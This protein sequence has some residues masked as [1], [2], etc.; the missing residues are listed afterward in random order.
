[1]KITPKTAYSIR[2]SIARKFALSIGVMSL[3][4]GIVIAALLVSLTI[5]HEHDHL[6]QILDHLHISV[7]EILVEALWLTNDDLLQTVLDGY[8]KLPGI[9]K[10]V[11]GKNDGVVFQEGEAVSKDFF[12]HSHDL[13]YR[14]Q[15][16]D[17]KLGH[18]AVTVGMD[19][20][21]KKIFYETL[22]LL[23][24]IGL[25]AVLGG[26]GTI[27]LFY[28]LVGR[29]LQ[30]IADHCGAL[31]WSNL[32]TP[33]ILQRKPPK[34]SSDELDLITISLNETCVS[35]DSSMSEVQ[36]KESLYKTIVTNSSDTILRMDRQGRIIYANPAAEEQNGNRWQ[37][38]LDRELSRETFHR[39]YQSKQ[40]SEIKL[41]FSD[42]TT[43]KGDTSFMLKLVP[44]ISRDGSVV[45]IVGIARNI[46]ME[47]QKED[48][49]RAVFK[50][51]PMP[52]AIAEI[53]SG[54]CYDVNDS[55]VKATGYQR[56]NIVDKSSIAVGFNSSENRDLVKK[57]LEMYG[58]F[59]DLELDFTHY[60]GSTMTCR[61]S[62]QIINV[63]GS[64]KMLSLF[65]DVTMEN[66]MR[67]E[68]QVLELQLLQ[69][70]KIEAI[71]TLAGGI[72]HDFN[73]ILMA[74]LGYGQMALEGTPQE[75]PVHRD[76]KQILLAA[77][78]ATQLTK[79]ILLFS[80]QGKNE[81]SP[82]R[83]QEIIKEVVKLLRS[84]IPATI[85]I[86]TDIDMNCRPA[87][88]DPTQIHQ[89][90]MNILTNARQ[91]VGGRYGK[92]VLTLREVDWSPTLVSVDG[93]PLKQCTYLQ[94]IIEDSGEGMAP[95]VLSR[96][97]EP[98]FTTKVKGE[99][100]GM[101][102]AVCHGIIS[103]HKGTIKV[104]SSPG[105]GA[106]FI[107]NLPV[108][109]DSEIGLR[110]MMKDVSALQGCERLLLVDDEKELLS[111]L[112]RSLAILGYQTVSFSDSIEGLKYF[113]GH[114]D[115]LD[116]VITDMTM[117]HLNGAEMSKK[118]LELRPDLP[119]I[120]CT[121]YSDV[122]D[123]EAAHEMGIRSYILKPVIISELATRM[124]KIFDGQNTEN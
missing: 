42:E 71:G 117:P 24:V 93:Q 52:M 18:I 41:H 85:E 6:K 25:L 98:F 16:Q 21:N 57:Q 97:F 34:K 53:D 68:Q 29:H 89:V 28:R 55:F 39:I 101:G 113:R 33:L 4:S 111:M 11:L 13:I 7:E 59:D 78:R 70:S 45:G 62:G 10:V 115:E 20:V 31:N 63:L 5:R 102:M 61:W 106:K 49:L 94:L 81:L 54:K 79:Q 69:A 110:P 116:M 14:Y 124:R 32:K 74:I 87:L 43:G 118:M 107:I 56:D 77:Q 3:L 103:R 60:N 95:E 12:M 112:E 80:R 86:A 122:L 15:G 66:K 83:L 96:I 46:T 58:F 76:L 36:V 104:V 9:E 40:S 108:T 84:T 27:L 48:L 26:A 105:K 8:V 37:E 92:I 17:V 19:P 64:K 30:S 109:E 123:A 22:F 90:L 75:S 73:N 121:G 65:H 2:V 38:C 47:D 114:M 120:I 67:R 23:A 91:A 72:A 82:Y 100:T 44:E 35:L 88:L 1:M 99:G 51:S 119:I 50:H